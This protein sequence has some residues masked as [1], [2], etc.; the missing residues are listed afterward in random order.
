MG[1]LLEIVLQTRVVAMT[2]SA[3]SLFLLVAV[4]LLSFTSRGVGAV[5]SNLLRLERKIEGLEQEFDALSQRSCKDGQKGKDA[6]CGNICSKD[7][8]LTFQNN[9][10]KTG[11]AA[12]CRVGEAVAPSGACRKLSK[13]EFCSRLK[14]RLVKYRIDGRRHELFLRGFEGEN[15]GTI[16][17]CDNDCCCTNSK[18]V[19]D[20]SRGD[21][22]TGIIEALEKC[23]LYVEISVSLFPPRLGLGEN[24]IVYRVI[25]SDTDGFKNIGKFNFVVANP[26]PYYKGTLCMLGQN[27]GC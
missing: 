9:A 27:G 5:D 6:D 22:R 14:G 3:A 4:A 26:S 1:S 10:T 23:G 16:L 20:S 13:P 17:K 24:C 15:E 11:R 12:C 18:G 25:G 21:D 19:F 2:H 7:H 8:Y